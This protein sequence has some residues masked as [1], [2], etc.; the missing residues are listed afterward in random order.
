VIPNDSLVVSIIIIAW[1]GVEGS[2]SE[3]KGEI[4][5]AN[6]LINAS[7]ETAKILTAPPKKPALR[8]CFLAKI[9]LTT[10]EA[11]KLL[12]QESTKPSGTSAILFLIRY[13]NLFVQFEYKHIKI[14]IHKIT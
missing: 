4:K 1:V 7:T 9:E 6:L 2:F 3:K 11:V 10:N 14:I 8:L 5:I 13:C 12:Q